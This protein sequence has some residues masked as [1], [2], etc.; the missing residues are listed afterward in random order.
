MRIT[1]PQ[2]G[3]TRD[4]PRE[5][6]PANS[7]IVNCPKCACRFRFLTEHGQTEILPED[8]TPEEDIRVIASQAY[9]AEA[10]RFANEQKA[11]VLRQKQVIIPWEAA[12][13]PNGWF[14]AFWQT[15]LLVM[16]QAQIFFARLSPGS[17]KLRALS[18]FLIICVFQT[19]IER[20]WAQVFYNF[21]SSAA[22]SDPQLQKLLALLAQ[23]DNIFMFL[24]MRT[25]LLTAQLYLFALFM[26]LA[27]RIAFKNRVSFSLIFQIIA[28]SSAPWL[29]C[30]VPGIGSLCGTIW[31][32]GCMAIGCKT[33]LEL[34]WP[35]T[36][37]GFI[38]FV[39]FLLPILPQLLRIMGQ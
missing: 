29:L 10:R 21:F 22:S 7:V 20:M 23:N 4:V 14:A 16:F 27:Y 17:E 12:P 33:A 36:L 1:C 28:Y 5:K 37:I 9:Q 32:V 35:K 15:V 31:G 11:A 19:L 6:I 25:C 18:F 38:P 8:K 30:L 2:C 13:A 24:A 3:F 39:F 34:D 26:Y